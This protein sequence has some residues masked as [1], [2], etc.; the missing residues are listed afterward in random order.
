MSTSL[1]LLPPHRALGWMPYVWLVYL[2]AYIAYP[3]VVRAGSSEWPLHAAGPLGF[4]PLYFAGYWLEVGHRGGTR[5]VRGH[6]SKL[7]W[8][9][10]CCYMGDCARS[11]GSSALVS[12]QRPGRSP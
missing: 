1:K 7:T 6:G 2:S 11:D 12:G 8:Q 4:L 9:A 5:R 10:P 3:F